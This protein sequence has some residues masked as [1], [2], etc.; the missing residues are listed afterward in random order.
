MRAFFYAKTQGFAFTSRHSRYATQSSARTPTINT[1]QIAMVIIWLLR[2][3][4]S[5]AVSR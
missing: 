5:T 3:A 2:S 4:G 1:P